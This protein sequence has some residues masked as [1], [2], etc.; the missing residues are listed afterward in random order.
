VAG[1][2][3]RENPERPDGSPSRARPERALRRCQAQAWI[4]LAERLRLLDREHEA[5]DL[6][7]RAHAVARPHDF[8]AEL[9]DIH[10]RRGNMLFARGDIDGCLAEQTRARA[11]AHRA[12]L[13]L[14]E[15]RAASGLGHAHYM[16]GHM[17]TAQSHYDHCLE[18]G[19]AHG[20]DD[21]IASNLSMRGLTRFYQNDLQTA[22]QNGEE[23]V[24]LAARVGHRRAE[25]NAL[26]HCTALVWSELGHVEIAH[27]ALVR[28]IEL[29]RELG[30]L[31]FE[32]SSWLFLGKLLAMQGR[33]D[34]ALPLIERSLAHSRQIGIAYVG[35]IAL[36]ALA[37]VTTDPTA[38]EQALAEAEHILRTGV[39]S[40]NHLYFYRD[41]MEVTLAMG[42]HER[43][44]RYALALE[45]FT[46]AEPLPWSDFFIARA[47]LLAAYA[48]G[49]HDPDTLGRIEALCRRGR[50]AGYHFA[51]EALDRAL[52]A[53]P[54]TLRGY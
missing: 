4:G 10:Y 9:A 38:R 20:F 34:E 30:A 21:V 27:Q 36:G 44:A 48:R 8:V 40:H 2:A 19:R 18:L 23:A 26:C 54:G 39:S 47:R 11:L 37:L 29:S 53:G 5:L 14:R 45:Q 28:A 22:L 6:L 15:A 43:L 13:P 1:T 31:R 17:I 3:T 33:Y 25:L 49:H 46:A 41:A 24:A 7:D 35:P 42:D 51:V 52:A 16:R 50:E 12:G 32:A